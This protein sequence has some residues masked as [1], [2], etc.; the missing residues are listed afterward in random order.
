M[1]QVIACKKYCKV[2]NGPTDL[3]TTID[4]LLT[5][6]STYKDVTSLTGGDLQLAPAPFFTPFS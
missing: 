4:S 1:R 2:C 5:D 6:T 3:C